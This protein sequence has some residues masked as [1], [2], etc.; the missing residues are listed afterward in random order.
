MD[1]GVVVVSSVDVGPV[2]G[3]G[4]VGVIMSSGGELNS[5]TS[6]SCCESSRDSRGSVTT[7]GHHSLRLLVDVESD[8]PPAGTPKAFVHREDV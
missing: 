2:V 3:E 8:M 1:G 7:G 4:P 5:A 6:I